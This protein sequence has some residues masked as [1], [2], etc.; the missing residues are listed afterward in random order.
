M[1][2]FEEWLIPNTIE[3]TAAMMRNVT[4]LTEEETRRLKN[5]CLI[6]GLHQ[7]NLPRLEVRRGVWSGL[8]PELERWSETESRWAQ[9]QAKTHVLW[10]SDDKL[11]DSS[12]ASHLTSLI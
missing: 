11:V 12:G 9:I 5:K 10:G 8:E 4:G 3:G 2:K 1:G 6:K 7:L